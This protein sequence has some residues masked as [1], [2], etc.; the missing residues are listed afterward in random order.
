MVVAARILSVVAA[1]VER[2]LSVALVAYT[3]PVVGS[4]RSCDTYLFSQRILQFVSV[5]ADVVL[6]M[7]PFAERALRSLSTR[8]RSTRL[9]NCK[10]ILLSYSRLLCVPLCVIWQ[11]CYLNLRI[12]FGF[13]TPPSFEAVYCYICS[14]QI[15]VVARYRMIG[16]VLLMLRPVSLKLVLFRIL[17]FHHPLVVLF[18]FTPKSGVF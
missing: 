15:V 12:I 5:A 10:D 11:N 9:L 7:I 8:S 6:R 14:R 2:I 18:Y 1:E 16:L 4:L 3:P 13:V 17:S